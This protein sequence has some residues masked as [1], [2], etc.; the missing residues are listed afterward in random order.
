MIGPPFARKLIGSLIAVT[1]FCFSA[2]GEAQTGDIDKA[3]TLQ[4]A[5][6]CYYNLRT[7]GLSDVQV[8]IQPNW[9][10][11]LEGTNPAPSA[12][13]LLN[14]LHFWISIDAADKLQLSHDAK[15]VPVDQV[16]AVEKIFKLILS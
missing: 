11:L 16:E 2:V 1:I 15:A 6:A 9:D 8:A 12:R 14:N 4:T 3:K 7:S 5:R 10:L 13:T